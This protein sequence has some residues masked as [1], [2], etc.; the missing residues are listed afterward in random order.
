MS[1]G[2]PSLIVNM[3]SSKLLQQDAAYS[4]PG[5]EGNTMSE[6]AEPFVPREV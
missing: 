2:G 5:H 1:A 4:S 6:E 3:C